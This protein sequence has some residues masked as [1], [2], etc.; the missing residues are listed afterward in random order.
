VTEIP[1]ASYKDTSAFTHVFP[2]ILDDIGFASR[3]H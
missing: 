3:S 2:D 1:E